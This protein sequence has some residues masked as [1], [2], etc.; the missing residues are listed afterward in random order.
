ML[1]VPTH[2]SLPASACIVVADEG[3]V[4]CRETQTRCIP[5]HLYP[6]PIQNTQWYNWL[7]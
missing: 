7:H 6:M 1:D 3:D 2:F 5:S 4:E